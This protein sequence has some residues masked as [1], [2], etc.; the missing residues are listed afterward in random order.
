MNQPIKLPARKALEPLRL[1]QLAEALE[2]ES[3]LL[4][5]S[6]LDDEHQ[7][8]RRRRLITVA[9]AHTV[10]VQLGAHVN[11][12]W[13]NLHPD[14]NIV[15]YHHHF[16]QFTDLVLVARSFQRHVAVRLRPLAALLL[17]DSTGKMEGID[18]LLDR[19]HH[20][21]L[22][23]DPESATSDTV[24]VACDAGRDLTSSWARQVE[25][26]LSD[27]AIEILPRPRS[28]ELH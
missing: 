5:T 18:T 8:T 16:E 7:S 17:A 6:W 15:P 9:V 3:L 20:A 22:K 4:A 1:P 23:D 12:V 14:G 10:L 28:G 13:H 25:H 27:P 11:D 24:R 21:S 26:L 19:L 2:R